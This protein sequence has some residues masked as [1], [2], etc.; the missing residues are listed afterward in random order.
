MTNMPKNHSWVKFYFKDWQLDIN[1]QSCSYGAR[2][3]WFE[4]IGLMTRSDRY[5]YLE[6]NGQPMTI[7][8]IANFTNGHKQYVIRYLAEL[9]KKGV[10]SKDENG[11]I[12]CRRMTRSVTPSVTKTVTDGVTTP[13]T[14]SVTKSVTQIGGKQPI[15]QDSPIYKNKNKNKEQDIS[16]NVDNIPPL[17]P[18][19][20]K[21]QI[22]PKSRNPLAG[23]ILPDDWELTDKNRQ[24][25]LDEGLDPEKTH[26]EFCDYWRSKAGANAKKRDW[27]AT[28][29]NWC[30][31]SSQYR[32]IH[33]FPRKNWQNCNQEKPGKF[34][35]MIEEHNERYGGF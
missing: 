24:C 11:V 8:Q 15:N 14:G 34:D 1:L 33:P 29:R 6:L 19:N 31:R 2:G 30:R 7:T 35:W 12:F 18:P 27:N 28:W 3:L 13:V 9:E 22:K 17:I 21:K 23:T 20:E 32:N 16:T 10:L 4:L 26:G 5:G 25:A